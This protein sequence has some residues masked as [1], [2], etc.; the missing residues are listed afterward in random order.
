MI[1]EAYLARVRELLPAA[2]SRHLPAA[3]AGRHFHRTYRLSGHADAADRCRAEGLD[4]ARRERRASR[5][6]QAGDRHQPW[7]QQRGDVAGGAGSARASRTSRGHHELVALRRAGGIV[8]RGRTASRHSWRRGRDLDHAGALSAHVRNE[9]I[10]DFRPT[11]HRDGKGIS[12]AFGAPAGRRSR[13]RRRTCT[14]AAPSATPPRPPRR[15]A[16][17]CSITARARSANCSPTSTNSIRNCFFASPSRGPILVTIC[18]IEEIIDE[19]IFPSRASNR[20]RRRLRPIGHAD[21]N[22]RS[23]RMEFLMSIKTKLPPLLSLP[24][25]LPAASL[26][27]PR[28]RP[29]RCTGVSEPASSAPPSSAPRSPLQPHGYYYDG[30]RR[31]GWVRQFDAYGN[32]MGRVRTCNY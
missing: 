8:F 24:L 16:N 10:A 14:Q 1:G 19:T 12:L 15:K 30:Y 25:P 9:A 32:Y 26:P 29:S 21:H 5:R 20:F 2:H 27:P 17:D 6:Q 23:T 11:Q 28:P 3:A 18:N 22:G 13:G 7:R 31:C 4:G